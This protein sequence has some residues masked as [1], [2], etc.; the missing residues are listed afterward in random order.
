MMALDSCRPR[1]R[2]ELCLSV[3][4]MSGSLGV[5]YRTV[6]KQ[7]PAVRS[8]SLAGGLHPVGGRAQVTPQ[9]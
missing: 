2:C 8:V 9:R 5:Q 3:S 7:F 1:S 4:F 6:R